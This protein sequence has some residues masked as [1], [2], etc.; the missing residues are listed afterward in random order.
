MW[1]SIFPFGNIKSDLVWQR[2]GSFIFVSGFVISKLC[3]KDKK[4]IWRASSV[5]VSGFVRDGGRG[6]VWIWHQ[7][8]LLLTLEIPSRIC[9]IHNVAQ[10]YSQSSREKK[11]LK[12]N[13]SL[14][15]NFLLH[16]KNAIALMNLKKF[17]LC[18]FNQNPNYNSSTTLLNLSKKLPYQ[19]SSVHST[20]GPTRPAVVRL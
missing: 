14:L 11:C 5:F 12:S 16:Y 4:C 3:S 17:Q 15:Q 7:L 9:D 20:L 6:K 13:L 10:I 8:W 18:S 1:E 19:L 2:R